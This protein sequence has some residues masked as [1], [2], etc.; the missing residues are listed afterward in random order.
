MDLR[1]MNS[2]HEQRRRA[3]IIV[4]L[5]K[6]SPNSFMSSFFFSIFGIAGDAIGH[7][8]LSPSEEVS[9]EAGR[10]RLIS[11]LCA[12]ERSEASSHVRANRKRQ[13]RKRRKRAKKKRTKKKKSG[14]G[15]KKGKK[16]MNE[17]VRRRI[18]LQD[19]L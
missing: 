8:A 19:E 15:L 9:G 2:S 13:G 10:A 7:A 17:A 6:V 14:K 5:L 18:E 1:S 11:E 16:E 12:A 3:R 4:V